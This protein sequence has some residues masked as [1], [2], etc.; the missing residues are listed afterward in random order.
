[1]GTGDKMTLK[2]IRK[3]TVKANK[4]LNNYLDDP[5][6]SINHPLRKANAMLEQSVEIIDVCL[7]GE[8]LECL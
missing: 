7:S 8:N 4:K 1:M 2:K 5:V 3:L 6:V